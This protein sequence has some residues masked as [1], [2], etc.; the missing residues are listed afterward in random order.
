[1]AGFLER[2]RVL[3]TV[4][5]ARAGRYRLNYGLF[6]EHFTGASIVVA[7]IWY[8]VAASRRRRAPRG[9]TRAA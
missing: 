4:Y 3:C 1:V 2:V 8:L 6:I 9:E 5:D 7:T